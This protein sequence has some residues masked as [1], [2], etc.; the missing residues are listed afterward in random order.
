ML[1]LISLGLYEKEDMSLKALEKAKECDKLYLEIYTNFF[2]DD[3]EKLSSFIGKKVIELGRE[4][5]ENRSDKLLEEAKKT[6]VG[7]LVGG[8]CLT[9]TTHS[10]LILDAKK[11]GIRVEIIHG[12]SILTAVAETGLFLYNFGKVTSIPFDNEKVEAP[13]D[14]IKQ[15]KEM[16]TLCLLDLKPKER[17]FMKAT[18]AISYLLSIEAKR[19]ENVF[20]EDALCVICAGLGSKKQMIK[21]GKAGDLLKEKPEVFP[22]CLIVPGKLH[23][24]ESAWVMEHSK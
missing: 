2:K 18:E 24:M 6:D 8:D 16:H 15:N 4:D 7:I 23:F 21:A 5:I 11:Q 20:N 3:A 14:V 22:Q 13:Y 17:K 1:R 10:S 19:K 9:A 12:S